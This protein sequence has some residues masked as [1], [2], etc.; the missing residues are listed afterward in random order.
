MSVYYQVKLMEEA[1]KEIDDQI[2]LVNELNS[3]VLK[4][5][6]S[7]FEFLRV[8]DANLMNVLENLSREQ[9]INIIM[10]YSTFQDSIFE[11]TSLI[12]EDEE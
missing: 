12:L 3:N 8:I 9:L 7:S 5:N 2:D 6:T 1:I 10:N 11:Q 4:G